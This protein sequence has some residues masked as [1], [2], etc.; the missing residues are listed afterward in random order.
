MEAEMFNNSV[1]NVFEHDGGDHTV[2]QC[3]PSRKVM[4]RLQLKRN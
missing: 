3:G 4:K 1:Q 2:L